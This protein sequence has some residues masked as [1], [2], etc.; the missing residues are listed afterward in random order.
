LTAQSFSLTAA[1][2]RVPIAIAA[3]AIIWLAMLIGGGRGSS[4]DTALARSLYVGGNDLLTRNAIIFTEIGRGVVLLPLALLVT[5]FLI[6]RRRRRAALFLI[7]V[8]GGRFLVELQKVVVARPRPD[9]SPHL[10]A[11]YSLSFPSGHAANAMITALA[12][13]L[14]LPVRQRNRAIAV[15]IGVA[16][17]L[18]IGAS[19]VMLGV[20]WPSDVIGG[21]AFGLMWVMVCM[22]LAS[23]RPETGVGPAR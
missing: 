5:C 23:M 7:M 6:W 1:R 22:R 14:L 10:A 3:T 20:H 12:I 11:V 13:A 21:W 2:A 16:L 9:E 18:Q 8:I 4:L 17:A 19:R 15:G